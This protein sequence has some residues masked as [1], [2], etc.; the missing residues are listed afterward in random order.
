MPCCAQFRS[1]CSAL[2][3]HCP[4]DPRSPKD[5]DDPETPSSGRPGISHVTSCSDHLLVSAFHR[6]LP[7]TVQFSWSV[8][9]TV[10]ILLLPFK[11]VT[12][13]SS[14]SCNLPTGPTGRAELTPGLSHQLSPGTLAPGRRRGNKYTREGIPKTQSSEALYPSPAVILLPDLES[15]AE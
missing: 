1:K 6:H 3:C 5:C 15:G 13:G 9:N 12:P 14:P 8:E 4:S 2:L 10:H 7:G 11:T